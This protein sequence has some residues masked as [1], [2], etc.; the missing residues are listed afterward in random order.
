VQYD[1]ELIYGVVGEQ[2]LSMLPKNQDYEWVLET[3]GDA[4]RR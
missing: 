1:S 2:F 4:L 3:L